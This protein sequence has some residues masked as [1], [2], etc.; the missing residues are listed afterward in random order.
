MARGQWALWA[1]LPERARL[2]LRGFY[3]DLLAKRR[4][5]TRLEKAALRLVA[6]ALYTTL[7]AS[8]LATRTVAAR[9]LGRGRRPKVSRVNSAIKRQALQ[10]RSL[11]D[12]LP[13]GLVGLLG[14]NGHAG[15]AGVDPL[16]RL[17]SAPVLTPPASPNGAE[18]C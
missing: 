13:G 3:R 4:P 10:L 12:M 2:D 9:Q 18:P 15:Q 11:N 7:G 6:E 17:R 1:E 14:G 16:E 8:D 5:R